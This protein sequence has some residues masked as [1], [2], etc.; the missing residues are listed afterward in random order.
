M[1]INYKP[2]SDSISTHPPSVSILLSLL[3][4]IWHHINYQCSGDSFR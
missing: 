2:L 4:N 1:L 3:S